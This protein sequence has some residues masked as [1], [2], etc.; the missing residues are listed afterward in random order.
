MTDTEWGR[1]V[2]ASGNIHQNWKLNI[3]PYNSL[4]PISLRRHLKKLQRQYAIELVLIDGLW[5]MEADA[6]HDRKDRKDQIDY[7][8]KELNTI[9][10]ETRLRMLVTHQLSREA[11]RRSNH[12]PILSDMSDSSAIEKNAH[13][14]MALFRE[15]YP[16]FQILTL[17]P[18]KTEVHVLKNRDSGTTGVA[19]LR[20]QNG[21]Y[22]DWK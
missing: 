7:I 18:D 6:T 16:S 17:T 3:I 11:I 8:T 1:F 14:I 22:M 5:L 9:A 20:W 21:R 13:I 4:T 10:D 2:H 19:E 15:S 12:Y